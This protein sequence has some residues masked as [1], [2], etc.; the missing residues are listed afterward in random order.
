MGSLTQPINE[1][2]L[3]LKSLRAVILLLQQEKSVNVP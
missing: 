1:Q 3:F 2:G